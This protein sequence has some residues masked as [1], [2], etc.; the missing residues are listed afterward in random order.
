MKHMTTE[1]ERQRAAVPG[2]EWIVVSHRPWGVTV[3][4]RAPSESG[5]YRVAEAEHPGVQWAYASRRE[6]YCHDRLDCRYAYDV[7]AACERPAQQIDMG[8]LPVPGIGMAGPRVCGHCY[9][10]SHGLTL[11][12]LRARVAE[13]RGP[14]ATTGETGERRATR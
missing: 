2:Y 13:V 7:C 10:L 11:A 4:C 3:T 6:C 12:E 5:A 9:R 8:T 1:R 14:G